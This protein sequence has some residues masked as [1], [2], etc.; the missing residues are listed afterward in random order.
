M[1]A[2]PLTQL[3][4]GQA[5][6]IAAPEPGQQLSLRLRELGF[7]PGTPVAVIRRGALGDPIEVELRGYRICIRRADLIHVRVVVGGAAQ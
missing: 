6:H 3:A 1:Q 5:G 2:F 7:V 4:P